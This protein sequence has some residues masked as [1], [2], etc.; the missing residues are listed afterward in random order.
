MQ[1]TATLALGLLMLAS[2]VTAAQPPKTSTAKVMISGK[3]AGIVTNSD[4][5]KKERFVLLAVDAKMTIKV[6]TNQDVIPFN[7]KLLAE[8]KAM[9]LEFSALAK[10]LAANN[11]VDG[12]K[13]AQKEFEE[14]SAELQSYFSYYAAEG[15]LT[16]VKGEVY[17]PGQLR[18]FAYKGADKAIG[19]GKA[20]VEGEATQVK[21]DDGQGAKMTLAIQN[22]GNPDRQDG[23]GHGQRQG[24]YS[25]PWCLGPE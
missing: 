6:V 20:L 8:H 5:V 12:I 3:E 21:F 15:S 9:F 22:A 4:G 17:L 19:K 16:I 24:N 18:L 1:T 14:A 13:K 23:P 7:D 10:K 11:D 2:P 25:R